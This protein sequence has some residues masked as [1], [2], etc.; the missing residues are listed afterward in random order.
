[1]QPQC[2][3]SLAYIALRQGETTEAFNCCHKALSIDSGNIVALYNLG[4]VFFNLQNLDSA[5]FYNQQVLSRD[6]KNANALYNVG[7][8]YMQR[9]QFV[10]AIPV[11]L[12][13]ASCGNLD[14]H[15]AEL[16]GVAYSGTGRPDL[17]DYW[18]NKA[19]EMK[20]N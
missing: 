16:L 18:W 13:A 3:N 5:L 19:R 4:E 11:F 17:A 20:P 7:Y 8:I 15:G 10:S 12:Y 6:R 1:M 14:G 9:S 2:W